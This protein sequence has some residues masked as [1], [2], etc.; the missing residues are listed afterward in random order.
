MSDLNQLPRVQALLSCVQ[1][2]GDEL[3]CIRTADRLFV[4]RLI[5]IIMITANALFLYRLG[6][7]ELLESAKK[8]IMTEP[9]RR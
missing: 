6:Y 4:F 1:D 8:N 7:I 2:N 5:I 9:G 3:N